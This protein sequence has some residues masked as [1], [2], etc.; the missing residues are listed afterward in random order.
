M[1]SEP[2]RGSTAVPVRSSLAGITL[3]LAAVAAAMTFGA[4]LT[5]LIG[6]PRSYG[7]NWDA[8]ISANGEGIIEPL[9]PALQTDPELAAVAI[10]DI[11]VPLRIGHSAVNG[12]AL[13]DV[14]GHISPIVL[15]GGEP[16]APD[17]IALGSKTL[18]DSGSRLGRPTPIKITA[19]EYQT[20]PKRIVGTVV[21]PP[22]SAAA[23]LGVGAIMTYD[24]QLSLVPPGVQPPAP[25]NAAIIFAPNVDRSVVLANL[26]RL[27]GHDYDV[28]T[29]QPPTDIVNFGRVQNLPL[30]L[31]GLLAALA[32]ATLGHA[33]ISSVH[34]RG[35]DIALLKTLGFTPGQVRSMIAWQSTTVTL[36]ALLIGV[37]VGTALGRLLWS[38][39]AGQL[40]TLSEPATPVL[41][42]ALIVPL[43]VVAA[44]LAAAIPALLAS[45]TKP[46]T[47]LHAK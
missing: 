34:R 31:A 25:T 5:H 23:R 30:I 17:E 18:R 32:V 10:M 19:V 13:K 22:A 16:L 39:F 44:N 7:W 45:R 38:V 46:A 35:R 4:S 20:A 27:A 42:L 3:A 29:P 41:S 14:K 6:S 24:C 47:L 12:I 9:I 26:R 43:A 15:H 11:G 8:Q 2:G 28:L 36:V 37:P 33:L 21:L 40:G 1:A